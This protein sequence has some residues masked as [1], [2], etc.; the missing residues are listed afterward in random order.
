[1]IQ[2]FESGFFHFNA[3][4]VHSFCFI[5]HCSFLVL[6]GILLYEYTAICLSAYQLGDIW[7]DLSFWRLLR[8]P[9]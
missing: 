3:F 8:K 2:A 4:E 6:S 7:V 5:H 9:V 1:M